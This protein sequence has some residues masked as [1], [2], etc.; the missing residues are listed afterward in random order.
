MFYTPG[1]FPN[2]VRE[3]NIV[4]NTIAGSGWGCGVLSMAH[5]H[6][7]RAIWGLVGRGGGTVNPSEQNSF[8][9]WNL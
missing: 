1:T 6:M 7:K 3:I 4:T 2:A 5:N 8:V 9:I